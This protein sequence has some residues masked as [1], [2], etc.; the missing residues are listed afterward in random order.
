MERETEYENKAGNRVVSLYHGFCER[1]Y[2]FLMTFS[3]GQKLE[4]FYLECFCIKVTFLSLLP[5][6]C[7]LFAY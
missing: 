1:E 4:Y 3:R 6:S 5:F 7:I 2:A